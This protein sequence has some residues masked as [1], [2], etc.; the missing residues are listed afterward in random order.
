MDA[1]PDVQ[2]DFVGSLQLA[3]K[4]W[5]LADQI[6]QMMAARVSLANEALATWLGVYGTQ[7][8]DR[9][10]TEVGDISRISAE[11]RTGAYGW[12][13]NWQ[14]AMDQQNRVLYARKVNRVESERSVVASVWGGVFGH[15]DLPSMPAPVGL[16]A[17]P[18]F[19]PTASLVTY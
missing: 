1:G 17:A 15:G 13:G 3:R 8:S 18:V 4:L 12:A 16:P 7:F 10:E 5:A 2:F 6:D 11:L 19:A 9:M 14:Q